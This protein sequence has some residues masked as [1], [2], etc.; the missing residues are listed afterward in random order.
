MSDIN[1]RAYK[2]AEQELLD[3]KIKEV[4]GYISA[5]LKKIEEKKEQKKRIEE[6]LRILKLDKED[7]RAGDFDKIK[8][9]QGKSPVAKNVSVVYELKTI[10]GVIPWYEITSGTY[11]TGLNTYYF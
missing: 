8:E 11:N 9:R 4:K 1:K 2:E 5:T 6:E 3:E 10:S 7:L